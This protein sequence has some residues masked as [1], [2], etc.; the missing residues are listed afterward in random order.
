MQGTEPGFAGPRNS[1]AKRYRRWFGTGRITWGRSNMAMSVVYGTA[2]GGIISEN[3]GGVV[4]AYIPDQLGNTI[5]LM[6]S[7]G[8]LTD[9]WTYWPYGEVRTRTGSNAT[10]F[11][12][13]GTLGYFLDTLN[14][15]FYV[16]AR[17]LRSDLARWL[18]VDP[19]WPQEQA[20]CYV[21]DTPIAIADPTGLWPWDLCGFS[22]WA[23]VVCN[24][25][26][27]SACTMTCGWS[28]QIGLCFKFQ[29][30]CGS[31]CECVGIPGPPD[32]RQLCSSYCNGKCLNTKDPMCYIKCMDECRRI[33]LT[34][35]GLWTR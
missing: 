23:S 16:R 26:M 27:I 19:L 14:K 6:N 3:R 11:T 1:Q 25:I 8:T 29:F 15:M 5:G 17:H 13:L 32:Y 12:F 21:N 24:T 31:V 2:F 20:F 35:D 18:T 28:G 4:S 22:T 7:A 10:P 9:S 33:Q 30:T 34:I